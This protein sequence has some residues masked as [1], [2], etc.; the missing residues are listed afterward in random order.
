MNRSKALSAVGS[1]K[2]AGD[3]K[4]SQTTTPPIQHSVWLNS[5]LRGHRA[6][7]VRFFQ[8]LLE[9]DERRKK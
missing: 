1:H 6:A 5:L 8:I 9:W 3:E 2:R 7:L 4:K